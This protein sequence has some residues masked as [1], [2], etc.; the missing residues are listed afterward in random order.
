MSEGT[1]K[2]GPVY[3]G[4]RKYVDE[5]GGYAVWLPQEWR[6]LDMMGDHKGWVFTPYPDHF[7][8][9]FSCE[10]ISLDYKVTPED[11]DILR[12]GFLE[13]I[14]Q[15]PDAVIEETRYDTGKMVVIMEAKFTFTEN[16][17]R[18]K[19][20][21]KS[22]YWGEANLVFIAQGA[23]VEDYEYW[24]PMFYNTMNAYELNIS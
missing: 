23:T 1:K 10:K 5:A 24:L 22:M 6:Q 7:D 12:E 3:T 4:I 18:R 13:G 17:Q 19:R 21:T 2:K 9:S 16:G 20:W 8:T 15:L 14:N 11:L